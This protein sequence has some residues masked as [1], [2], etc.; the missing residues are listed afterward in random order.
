[1]TPT[2]FRWRELATEARVRPPHVFML[3]HW[4]SAGNP[5]EAFAAFAKLEE[6]HTEAMLAALESHGLVPKPKRRATSVAGAPQTRGSRLPPAMQLPDDWLA[7]A[8]EKRHWTRA[9][10]EDVLADFIEHFSNR[11]DARAVKVDWTLTWQGWVRRDRRP[12]GC[13]TPPKEGFEALT[14]NEQCE[15]AARNWERMDNPM[16]AAKWRKKMR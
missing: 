9:T 11:T 10:T 5:P 1:M 6:R 3:W 2:D 16:E 15:Q 14:W 8:Q 7:Y 4:L 13:W 12:D